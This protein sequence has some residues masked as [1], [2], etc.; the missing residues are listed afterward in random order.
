[1]KFYSITYESRLLRHNPIFSYYYIDEEFMDVFSNF[2][3]SGHTDIW[4]LL[5]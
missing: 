4:I 3:S 1:M 2:Y 5:P